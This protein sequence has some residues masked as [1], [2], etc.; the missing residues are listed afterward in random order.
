[1][2]AKHIR[3]KFLYTLLLFSTILQSQ[4]L[5]EQVVANINELKK[6]ISKAEKADLNIEKEKMTLRTAEIFLSYSDWDED[7][8]DLNAKQFKLVRTYWKNKKDKK[9]R[10]AQ[11]AAAYLPQQHREQ[12]LKITRQAISDISSLKNGTLRRPNYRTVNFENIRIK[13]TDNEEIIVEK[14][15]GEEIPTFFHTYTF[16]PE[17]VLADIYNRKSTKLKTTDYHGS[18]KDLFLTG[19]YVMKDGSLNGGYT[20]NLDKKIKKNKKVTRVF[21]DHRGI[22][23]YIRDENLNKKDDTKSIYAGAR[24]FTTYDINNPKTKEI[25]SNLLENSIPKY[26]KTATSNFAYMMANEPHWASIEK[27]YFTPNTTGN[28]QK[29]CNKSNTCNNNLFSFYTMKEFEKHLKTIYGTGKKGLK[30][31]NKNWY[32]TN[33]TKYLTSYA[34]IAGNY[35]PNEIGNYAIDFPIKNSEVGTPYTYDWFKFN[36]TRVTEWFK[37]I[38]TTIKENDPDARTHIKLIPLFFSSRQTR[39]AGLDFEALQELQE[40]IG[41]DAD[42]N[43]ELMSGVSERW[44]ERYNFNWAEMALT[45]DFLSSVK[46]NS[47]NYNSENHYVS[48]SGFRDL[49]LQPEYV[50]SAFWLA[51]M[52]GENASQIWYWPRETDGSIRKASQGKDNGYGASLIHQPAI[53]NEIGNVFYDMNAYAKDIYKIQNSRK[54]IRIFHSET[55]AINVLDHM[56]HTLDL[57]ESIFFDGLPIG[58]VTKNIINKQDNS[59]WDA[60]LIYKTPFVTDSEFETLQTYLDAG[61][62]IILDRECLLKNE[63]GHKR[64]KPLNVNKGGKL[65]Y[66]NT[67]SEIRTTA[68]KSIGN[69]NT[70]KL[71]ENKDL[72]K[73]GC[74]WRTLKKENNKYVVCLI[75]TGKSST[76]ISLSVDGFNEIEIT[77]LLDGE[78]LNSTIS[79]ELN[80]VRY[81]EVQAK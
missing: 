38:H 31:L 10:D 76:E 1:M 78:K 23:N 29:Q 54:P 57:Y 22:P 28:Q 73:R 44:M 50:K 58:F 39:D 27:N 55:T 65:I 7:H 68:L 49:Y 6:E 70:L 33:T 77:D 35:T 30:K 79:L 12:I 74:F 56:E 24:L 26:K 53:V 63:Y 62:T 3:T 17:F 59:N 75:N 19:R 69:K 4:N 20:N 81:I 71:T 40:I 67:T 16:K 46:P 25:V 66:K 72:D 14:I 34:D 13:K 42:M 51:Y 48:T 64:T 2:F 43:Q 61:G 60:I 80:D 9:G 15:K 18:I 32:G 41:N 47:I 37:F 8:V 21:V 11:A 45:F 52:L 5:R 36:N